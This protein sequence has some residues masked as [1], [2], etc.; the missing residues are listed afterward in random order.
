VVHED[1][2]VATITKE[3]AAE[4]PNLRGCFYPARRFRIKISWF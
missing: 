3:S 4:I 1:M 2:V